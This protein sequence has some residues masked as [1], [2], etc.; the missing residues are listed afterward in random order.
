MFEHEWLD[1]GHM[2][3]V[4]AALAP[5]GWRRTTVR[6]VAHRLVAAI[7][8]DAVITDTSESGW[9]SG[10]CLRVAGGL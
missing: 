5:Y 6:A 4:E 3:S 1:D 8:G 9:S 10:R 7:D 2:A